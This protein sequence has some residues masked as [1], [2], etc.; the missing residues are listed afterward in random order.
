MSQKV[1][2]RRIHSTGYLMSQIVMHIQGQIYVEQ[3]WQEHMI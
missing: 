2:K 3:E 1:F